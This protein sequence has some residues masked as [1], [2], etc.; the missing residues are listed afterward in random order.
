MNPKIHRKNCK[1]IVK[2]EE[3]MILCVIEGHHISNMLLDYVEEFDR[4]GVEIWPVGVDLRKKLRMP[5]SFVGKAVCAEGDEWNEELGRKI[6]YSRAKNKL[7]TSFFRRANM[8]INEVDY[9]LNRM[10]S[11]LND[12]GKTLD[13]QRVGLEQSIEEMV[14]KE[15]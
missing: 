7:Y 9:K 6:A 11:R 4:S 1:F 5:Y 3:R 14:Q 10:I 8:F 15:E 13:D 12:F 2:P